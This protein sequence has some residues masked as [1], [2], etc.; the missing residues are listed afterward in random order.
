MT[1]RNSWPTARS[2]AYC[3]WPLAL[4]LVAYTI[5]VPALNGSPTDD[6]STVYNAIRRMVTGEPIY[7]E[8][9]NYVDPHY[10]YSPGATLFLAPLG[11]SSHFVTVRL[12]FIIANALA[13]IAALGILT[14]LII[15]AAPS[16][17]WP[18]LVFLAFCTES[19]RNTLIFSNIN[20]ILLLGL[21]IFLWCT[22]TNHH[23]W[24]GLVL[25]IAILIKPIFGPLL[26]ISLLQRQWRP[27]VG[28]IG[29]PAVANLIALAIIP[30][31]KD[32]LT[33]TMPYL[34][35]VR[36]YSNSS[37]PGIAVYFRLPHWQLVTLQALT[38]LCLL[39]VLAWAVALLRTDL[40][41][42]VCLISGSLLTGIFLLSSLGQMYYSM[43]LFPLLLCAFRPN[44]IV[45]NPIVALAVFAFLSPGE[46]AWPNHVTASTWGEYLRPTIGWMLLMLGLGAAATVALTGMFSRTNTVK[47]PA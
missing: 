1:V 15:P 36:D 26:L 37:L 29:I 16:F 17:V 11:L 47:E 9:Y 32:Y 44:S 33:I 22:V 35:V 3:L 27:F 21:A 14:K 2:W 30:S 4:A 42:A 10:L 6:F 31:A 28:A 43:F 18:G 23:W 20:G 12:L 38:I 7:S 40:V 24:A 5:A 39:A 41:Q 46:L 25:G 8:N 19:V 34:K 13:I 45:R